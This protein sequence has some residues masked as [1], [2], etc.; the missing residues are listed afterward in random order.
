MRGSISSKSAAIASATLSLLGLL[1]PA[2][3]NDFNAGTVMQK[4]DPNG[5]SWY[6]Q[7]V[8]EGLAYARYQRDNQ[9]VEGDAKTVTGMKCV[10]DWFYEK[11]D[12]LKLVFAAFDTFPSYPPAAIISSLLKQSCP[13]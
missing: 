11:P 8:I 4:M 5:R 9:H 3:A 12:T 2:T 6:V 10:Y 13:E 7:G 1:S